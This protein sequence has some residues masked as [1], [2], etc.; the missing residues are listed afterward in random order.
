MIQ[1]I[2]LITHDRK[3]AK[4]CN[5][6]G[7]TDRGDIYT[8]IYNKMLEELGEEAKIKREDVKKAIMTM[9]YGSKAVPER[10]FGEDTPLLNTFYKVCNKEIPKVME[11]MQMCLDLWN[12]KATEY[13]WIMPDGFT[14]HTKVK[15]AIAER[16]NWLNEPMD[17]IRYIE[18]PE[19]EGRS[20]GANS[21]HSIDSLM[22]REITTRCMISKLKLT[23]IKDWLL[24]PSGS[25]KCYDPMVDKL[26]KLYKQSGFL[27]A[28]IYDY[29]TK[30]NLYLIDDKEAMLK[31]LNTFPTTEFNVLAI[32]DCYKCLPKYG[33]DVREQYIKIMIKIH[34]SNMLKFIF[35]QITGKDLKFNIKD[36]FSQ[37]IREISDYALS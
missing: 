27:S 8:Y 30:D 11:F 1:I 7:N 32:H 17:L 37:E 29:I 36:D 16:F 34:K 25:E 20:L 23:Y 35:D 6:F 5:V 21:V 18:K 4:R 26:W 10:V 15:G 22:V 33:N 3:A 14:V 24:N 13:S 31:D 28:R 2:S 19:K 9:A 12:P